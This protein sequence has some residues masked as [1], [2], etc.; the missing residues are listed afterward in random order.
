MLIDFILP[1]YNEE[2]IL[3]KNS[4]KLLK[5]LNNQN[6]NFNWRISLVLNGI[7]DNSIIIAKDLK[8][9]SSKIDFFIIKE[10]A[11]GRALKTYLNHS[12]ADFL[13]YMDVDLA[14]SLENINALLKNLLINNYD[15]VIGSRLLPESKT[16]R[17]FFRELSSRIYILLSQI[18]LRHKFSDL[19]CGFKG[20]T[21]NLFLNI[22][23]YIEDENWFFDTELLIFSNFLNY[24]IK[25]IPIDW[26]ENRYEKRVS[27]IN[28]LSDSLIFI[29]NLLKLKNRLKT[30]KKQNS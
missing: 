16:N 2:Q 1:C 30:V 8:K 24:K 27:K 3:E 9:Q 25:E 15:L 12:S 6:Y 21:K 18:I 20:M 17:S 26:A 11:K 22:S 7:T 19:Q 23:K 14:V 13:I 28:I 5:F 29:K 10:K 4:L